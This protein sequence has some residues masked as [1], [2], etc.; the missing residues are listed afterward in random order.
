MN[1]QVN[2]EFQFFQADVNGDGYSDILYTTNFRI[3]WIS[4][5]PSTMFF[6]EENLC[7]NDS[8]YFGDQWITEEGIY[9]D[10]LTAV[11]GMDSVVNLSITVLPA[12]NNF[13]IYGAVEILSNSTEAYTAPVDNEIN[14]EWSVEG[15]TIST[16]P[17]N[18][19]IT[20]LWG[21]IDSGTVTAIAKYSNSCHTTS[22]LNVTNINAI[23]D[24]SMSN[25]SI[26]P[27]PVRDQL[28]IKT[29]K[30]FQ[31]TIYN[32]D[33]KKLIS[34]TKKRIDV[35]SLPGGVYFIIFKD[36]EGRRFQRKFI[37]DS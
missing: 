33:G 3:V 17:M 25:I 14:Y 4:N 18:N 29:D 15:G 2:D 7:D 30:E 9:Q 20:V 23:N 10:S 1:F 28:L 32:Q 19:A 31:L 35:S 34:T 13:E 16:N 26:G 36:N 24:I 11:S 21:D 22:V 5:L 37:K 27:I 8:L 12:P 6:Y